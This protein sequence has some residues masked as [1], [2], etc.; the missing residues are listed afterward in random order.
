MLLLEISKSITKRGFVQEISPNGRSYLTSITLVW[1]NQ[2]KKKGVV[3]I[4][5]GVRRV[6]PKSFLTMKDNK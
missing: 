2:E 1:V 3:G 4:L 6:S 5:D